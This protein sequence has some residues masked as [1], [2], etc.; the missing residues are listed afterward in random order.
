MRLRSTPI[1]VDRSILPRYPDWV[2]MV[3]HPG[4]EATGPDEY[5]LAAVEPW[6]HEW[7][8]NAGRVV[9]NRI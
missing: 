2:K 7:Q 6:L 1:C 4:L 8:K 9:E 5:D 3:M